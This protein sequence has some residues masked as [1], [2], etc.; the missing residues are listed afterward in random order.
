MSKRPA[1]QRGAGAGISQR[2]RP[3]LP[4]NERSDPSAEFLPRLARQ[5]KLVAR[6]VCQ[7]WTKV[8]RTCEH[9]GDS[10]PSLAKLWPKSAEFAQIWPKFGQIGRLPH[11]TRRSLWLV[12]PCRPPILPPSPPHPPQPAV[13]RDMPALFL[14]MK[15]EEEASP[16]GRST[17]CVDGVALIRWDI[18]APGS[19][20]ISAAVSTIVAACP[21]TRL[22][23]ARTP[24]ASLPVSDH[25]SGKTWPKLGHI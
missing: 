21:R 8:D 25:L 16:T 20:M 14:V 17:P 2:R 12:P 3:T 1:K 19:L 15:H 22:C 10:G 11:A 6:L 13:T 7:I 5:D 23:Q 24:S 4:T 9:L 18:V